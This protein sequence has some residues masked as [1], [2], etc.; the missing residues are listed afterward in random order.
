MSRSRD[1]R[2]SAGFVCDFAAQCVCI[3]GGAPHDELGVRVNDGRGIV[4][5]YVVP[6]HLEQANFVK[7]EQKKPKASFWGLLKKIH[8]N[9]KGAVSIETILIVAAIAI[10][11]LLFLIRVG[12]P[13]IKE[14]FNRGLD[15]L[16]QDAE[17][18]GEGGGGGLLPG[19]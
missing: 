17:D 2:L 15:D 18:F 4:A 5:V 11:I 10:P 6:P 9:E 8:R 16:E 13:R 12:V 1:D 3:L 14:F 7:T 19:F